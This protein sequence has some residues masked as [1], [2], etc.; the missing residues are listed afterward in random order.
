MTNR[1]KDPMTFEFCIGEQILMRH[2]G[3]HSNRE[4]KES[5]P[6]I[7]MGWIRANF[8]QKR[9]SDKSQTKREKFAKS[10]SPN[11]NT[12]IPSGAF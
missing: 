3:D 1:E 9:K 6:F 5:S 4:D 8:Q 10:G 11:G 12:V 7:G 2:T